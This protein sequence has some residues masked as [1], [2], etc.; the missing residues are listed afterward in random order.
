MKR[1]L[2]IL[3]V[4]IL[5]IGSVSAQKKVVET[6]TTE[7]ETLK[8]Q[9]AELLQQIEALKHNDTKMQQQLSDAKAREENVQQR[10]NTLTN[11]NAAL[12]A[13]QNA[14]NAKMD[15]VVGKV[16]ELV[17][18]VNTLTL[19]VNELT[20]Q[21]NTLNTQVE[22]LND[23]IAKLSARPV[24]AAEP[25]KP[26]YEVVGEMC[27]GMVLVKEGLLYGYVNSKSEY[28]I[29]AQ[30]EEAESFVNG[31][32]RVKKNDKWGVVN[33]TGEET[34]AC[35]YGEVSHFSGTIWKVKQGELY[36]LLSAVNGAVVQPLKY[37]RIGNIW[38]QR[39]EM[40]INGKYG[41]FDENGKTV[42]AAQYDTALDFDESG[43]TCVS[44]TKTPTIS[45]RTVTL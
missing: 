42:I 25:A 15:I 9:N 37:T 34:I 36:G 41:F 30:Y 7:V 23:S 29:P 20:T 19:Q 39:A 13:E 11:A 35:S 4:A 26:K 18:Q 31:Y 10:L 38:Y 5:A 16:N 21:V 22:V 45:T 28:I 2:T 24:V 33:T 3:A 43:L 17:G 40:C 14:A 6:L 12:K 8:Q 27:N 1:F 44:R 32:A